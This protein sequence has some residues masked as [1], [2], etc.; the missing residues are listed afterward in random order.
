MMD[1]GHSHVTCGQ[2]SPHWEARARGDDDCEAIA[3]YP[4]S[5]GMVLGRDPRSGRSS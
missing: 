2:A 4:L 1:G 3:E 5:C